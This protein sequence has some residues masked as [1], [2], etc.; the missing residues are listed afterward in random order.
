[1]PLTTGTM[2]APD[3]VRGADRLTKTL[4]AAARDLADLSPESL[5]AAEEISENAARRAPHRTGR[6]ARSGRVGKRGK[7][8]VV[9]F[10]SGG[11]RYARAI[12]FGV[13]ARAGLRGPHN[14]RA[15]PFLDR[16]VEDVKPKIAADFYAPSIERTLSKI[17]GQ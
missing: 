15:N 4:G 16:A 13:D 7:A 9:R 1:M 3:K 10:G 12:H 5:A 8:A 14:I 17:Q 2:P 11:V 6:L